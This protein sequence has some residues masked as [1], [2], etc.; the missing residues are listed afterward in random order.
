V[1]HALAAHDRSS[2][3]ASLSAHA[4]LRRSTGPRARSAAHREWLHFCVRDADLD[5]IVNLSIV[6]DDRVARGERV[7]LLVLARHGQT[8]RGDLAEIDPDVIELRGGQLCARA[9]ASVI[10]LV[11]DIIVLRGASRDGALAFDLELTPQVFPSLARD[12]AIGGGSPINWL[13]VPRLAATGTVTLDGIS[14]P[15]ASALA[16]HDHN[17][18]HFT[19]R[20]F[21]WQWGHAHDG[22][23]HTVVVAR[24]LDRAQSTCHL[25]TLMLWRSTRIERIFR[26]AD[27]TV[28]PEGFLRPARMLTLPRLSSLLAGGATEVPRTLEIEAAGDG[29]VVR[30]AFT[31]EDLARI[32]VPEADELRTTIIHEVVGRLELRGTVRGTP[33]HIDARAI[34]ELL[35]GTR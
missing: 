27:L 19:H 12:V 33:V 16:Y 3:L 8:W 20:D 30:G 24:L 35:Q 9:G 2:I 22:G 26:G 21:T 5:L 25:Q 17:W 31:A 32:V 10:E 7:R 29:D 11:G 23:E 15:L 1:T 28:R 34:F 6:D 13:V 4:F 14:R 18:G